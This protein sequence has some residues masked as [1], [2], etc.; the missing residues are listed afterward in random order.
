M[1][2]FILMDLRDAP[3]QVLLGEL[4]GPPQ[5]LANKWIHFLLPI[6][7]QALAKLEELPSRETD[8]AP[9]AYMLNM[10]LVVSKDTASSKINSGIGRKGSVI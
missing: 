3:K 6:L 9:N 7:N 1:L 4:F 8:P 5:P 2:L 10:Q